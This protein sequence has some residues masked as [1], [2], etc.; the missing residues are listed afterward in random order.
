[1]IDEDFK[2]ELTETM[3]ATMMLEISNGEVDEQGT[4]KFFAE[5][6]D[7]DEKMKIF[8][9][10]MQNGRLGQKLKDNLKKI[11]PNLTSEEQS[12]V[13]DSLIEQFPNVMGSVLKEVMGKFFQDNLREA[14]KTI[15]NAIKRNKTKDKGSSE[16]ILA[17]DDEIRVKYSK[18]ESQGIKPSHIQGVLGKEYVLKPSTI[19]SIYYK[20]DYPQ[21]NSVD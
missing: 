14:S 2:D 5:H 15:S 16:T 9:Y 13:M 11:A 7:I 10:E 3:V 12:T 4:P 17:R 20:Y 6:I 21:K 19:K 1:M 18:M 8:K